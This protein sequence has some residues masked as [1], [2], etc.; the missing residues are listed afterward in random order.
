MVRIFLIIFFS[1]DIFSQEVTEEVI[2]AFQ[3]NP[4]LIEQI[5]ETNDIDQ[6]N[7]IVSEDISIDQQLDKNLQQTNVEDGSAIFGFD[8]INT[9]PTSIS[10]TSDLPVPSDYVV[11][12][13]DTLKVIL[14]GGERKVLNLTVGLDGNVLFPGVGDI[15]IFGDS[16]SDVKKKISDLVAVSYVGTEASVSIS[17][18]SAR[19]INII[20]AVKNPG[21]Y[22]VNPFSTISSA[23]A[24]SGGF[25]DFA[26]LRNI[27]VLRENKEL[28]F[29]LYDLLIK[30]NRMADIN[31][32]QGDVI[33]VKSTNNF[34]TVEGSVNRP[35]IYE[36]K[37]N[38]SVNDLVAFAMGPTKKANPNKVAVIHYSSDFS[39]QLVKETKLKDN[40]LLSDLNS[41]TIISLFD[42][43]ASDKFAIKVIG[44]IENQGY[45]VTPKSNILSELI[46]E[47]NFTDRVNPFVA[48]LQNGNNVKLFSLND[49]STQALALEKN[50]EIVFFD[51][52]EAILENE[53]LTSNSLEAINSYS[54]RV[55]I[56]G[57]SINFPFFGNLSVEQLI[58][59]M[60]FDTKTLFLDQTTY[61]SPLSEY[62]KTDSAF[63]LSFE[64]EPLNSLIFRDLA[65]SMINVSISGEVKLPGTYTL[66]PGSSLKDLYMLA[67]GYTPRADLYG[68]IFTRQ[69]VLERNLKIFENQQNE[70]KELIFTQGAN[71]SQS[72]MPLI[73]FKP[74]EEVLGRISGNLSYSSDLI[75][76]FLLESG[77]A[78]FI[79][80]AIKT[81]SVIGEVLNPSTFVYQNEMTVSSLIKNSG[82]YTQ[83]A[84]ERDIYLIKSNGQIV[85]PEGIFARNSKV[86]PGDTIIV[87][88]DLFA[89]ESLIEQLAPLTA[90]MSNLAFTAAALDNLR[91]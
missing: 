1:I 56:G 34:I 67:G 82:G 77:D 39:D 21:I 48:V 53:I 75:E 91:N 52:D 12:L 5:S 88:K 83:I 59:F 29:D 89:N 80:R 14:T 11:S 38:E 33:H 87:P 90:L 65:D 64:A 24:Y 16:L 2:N 15:N 31:I 44:P 45:F 4:S 43:K 20:G 32:Q 3:N 71:E 40:V 22:I 68:V 47:L 42:I 79:P 17:N 74:D 70:F 7:S 30:G 78:I 23:L 46:K 62:T 10:A 25:E 19:K 69:K 18:I 37:N 54:L 27:V 6:L 41:P 8:F 85:I 35:L 36:Y 9:I 86:E 51:K 73:D 13:G 76:N 50:S 81:V 84:N 26:S 66:K 63:N 28:V 72:L 58:D 61:I 57:Q 49:S 60:G 55:I